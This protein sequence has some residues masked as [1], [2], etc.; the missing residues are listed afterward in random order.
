MVGVRTQF[1][2]YMRHMVFINL[3]FIHQPFSTLTAE[4][5]TLLPTE[6]SK[7]HA[8]ILLRFLCNNVTKQIKIKLTTKKTYIGPRTPFN[9]CIILQYIRK[10]FAKLKF[11]K[12]SFRN[13]SG[14]FFFRSGD[15]F[16]NAWCLSLRLSERPYV[17]SCCETGLY[18]YSDASQWNIIAKLPR[19]VYQVSPGFFGYLYIY[20][21]IYIYFR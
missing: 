18:T 12:S 14:N 3:E 16:K 10:A 8:C 7:F 19:T 13:L 11:H 2:T 9:S 17:S 5:K 15:N 1:L 21:Y 4:L 6:I 20:I